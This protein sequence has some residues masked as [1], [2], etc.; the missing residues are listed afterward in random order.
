MACT[1]EHAC[2]LGVLTGELCKWRYVQEIDRL[3]ECISINESS[4]GR[5]VR[6]SLVPSF[7]CYGECQV[8]YFAFLG[9]IS[10]LLS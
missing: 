5:K 3:S 6:N 7:P 9:S 4:L 8:F 10:L 2:L 1:A